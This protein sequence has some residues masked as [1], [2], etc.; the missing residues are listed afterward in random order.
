MA[1]SISGKIRFAGIVLVLLMFMPLANAL[2]AGSM[3]PSAMRGPSLSLLPYLDFFVDQTGSMDI[4]EAAA[5]ERRDQYRP[6]LDKALPDGSGTVWL[7]FMLAPLLETGKAQVLL[8]DMGSGIP[9]TPVLYDAILNNLSGMVEW[10]ETLP[11]Q[12]NILILPEAGQ[13]ATI[14]YIRLDGLPG[15]WFDPTV[16][17]PQNAATDWASMARPAAILALAVVMLLCLLRGISE[18]GQW[19]YWTALYVGVALAQGIMGMPATGSGNISLAGAWSVLAPGVAL[20][21]LPHVGRHLMNTQ[22]RSRSIDIQLMLL[23]LPGAVLA[24]VPLLPQCVWLA[25]HVDMWPLCTICFIPTAIGA[26]IM[27]LGGS[28]RFLLGCFLPPFFVLIGLIGQIFA[29][30]V[31]ILAS[32]PLWGT[33][34]SALILA[35]TS[36]PHGVHGKSENPEHKNGQKQVRDNPIVLQELLGD[37]NLRLVLPNESQE[38]ETTPQ[39]AQI[40][41]P[42]TD[43]NQEVNQVDSQTGIINNLTEPAYSSVNDDLDRSVGVVD[44]RHPQEHSHGQSVDLHTAQAR[45]DSLILENSLRAPIEDMLREGAVISQ[46]ALPPVARKA[47]EK[48][49]EAARRMTQLLSNKPDNETGETGK[50]GEIAPFNLQH[51]MRDVHDT[52]AVAAENAGIAFSW[53]MPP[54]IGQ[55][56]LGQG[57]LLAT[58]L[59]QLVESAVRATSEGNVRLS[60][61]NA[62]E[63]KMAGHLLFTISD[64]GSGMP[65]ERRSGLALLRAWELV[66]DHNGSIDL[67][68]G[69]SGTSISFT[70]HLPVYYMESEIRPEKDGLPD[71]FGHAPGQASS[72]PDVRVLPGVQG[73]EKAKDLDAHSGQADHKETSGFDMD[74]PSLS[75]LAETFAAMSYTDIVAEGKN[76]PDF[77]SGT[78]NVFGQDSLPAEHDQLLQTSPLINE[79]QST[80]PVA[81][82]HDLPVGQADWQQSFKDPSAISD[83]AGQALQGDGPEA[84]ANS[85]PG[86]DR[87]GKREFSSGHESVSEPELPSIPVTA[88]QPEVDTDQSPIIPAG[89][90]YS[91]WV[92]PEEAVQPVQTL[93]A[94]LQTSLSD[95]AILSENVEIDQTVF[96]RSGLDS[97]VGLAR[98]TNGEVASLSGQDASDITQAEGLTGQNQSEPPISS[99]N[100]EEWVGEP[101]PIGTPLGKEADDQT[102]AGPSSLTTDRP[103][104]NQ[105]DHEPVDSEYLSINTDN[106]IPWPDSPTG[107]KQ[108]KEVEN[109]G[110]YRPAEQ[111][112]EPSTPI[113]HGAHSSASKLSRKSAASPRR[114]PQFT[115]RPAR[116]DEQ[117]GQDSVHGTYSSPSL[118]QAGEWVGEPQPILSSTGDASQSDQR[119]LVEDH[120]TG[121]A[122]SDQQPAQTVGTSFESA[123]PAVQ[124]VASASQ[125]KALQQLLDH[126]D[127]NINKA[128]QGLGIQNCNLVAESAKKIAGEADGFGLRVLA[129]LA[130]CVEQAARAND[131]G[132][133]RDL[134]P[135]LIVAIERTHVTLASQP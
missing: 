123:A 57:E 110:D 92:V 26:W 2:S 111:Q 13:D 5:T 54:H 6:Y 129:R 43:V 8:L 68:S 95:N 128:R 87:D 55:M 17:T 107:R 71:I 119:S 130:R 83:F 93:Q 122:T 75:S 134:L 64:T 131:L 29:I 31:N 30:D 63:S 114:W 16:R 98:D 4:E 100:F 135:D 21:L 32:T 74:V 112:Q 27:G 70:L 80:Q 19:R 3:L 124:T 69:E 20:M 66:A 9:G 77:G 86:D 125:D 38:N 88:S 58:V 96:Q 84:L 67:A 99:L 91:G 36:T 46:C 12:G 85:D 15:Q 73:E 127:E 120:V 35:A 65:P 61:R 109:S 117:S 53:S 52:Y 90:D 18:H 37:P 89:P 1:H 94:S 34:L 105:T 44:S 33:A 132:A 7:R 51:I 59:G 22:V 23:S 102:G 47:A 133:V 82:I 14:C 41:T 11:D 72:V 108:D 115:L 121:A 24:L 103:G 49:Y 126:L 28:R 48:M 113:A 45:P 56:Y 10:R 104:Q 106:A 39:T 97:G 81:E 62:P 40:P 78:E 25:R 116:A 76:V 42:I 118:S 60:V 50:G 101:T 79:S